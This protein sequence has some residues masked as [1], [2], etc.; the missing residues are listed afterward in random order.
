MNLH[1]LS[2]ED[3]AKAFDMIVD[4]YSKDS[5]LSE[6]GKDVQEVLTFLKEMN[7]FRNK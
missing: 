3:K 2:V 5:S 7:K 6:F 1:E 4:K